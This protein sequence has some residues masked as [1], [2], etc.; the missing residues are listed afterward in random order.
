MANGLASTAT[1][2]YLDMLVDYLR[3]FI[4][5]YFGAYYELML[6]ELG[7]RGPLIRILDQAL[8]YEVLEEGAPLVSYWRRLHPHDI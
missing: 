1:L 6:E 2:L 5:V 4:L 8:I 3:E 7:S